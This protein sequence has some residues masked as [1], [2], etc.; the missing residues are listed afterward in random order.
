MTVNP[1]LPSGILRVGRVHK[2]AAGVDFLNQSFAGRHF[3]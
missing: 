2:R 3:R 1:S